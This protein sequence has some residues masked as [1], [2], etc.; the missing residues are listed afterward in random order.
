MQKT[1]LWNLYA[2]C[3]T[4]LLGC[5]FKKT[6]NPKLIQLNVNFDQENAPSGAISL[7]KMGEKQHSRLMKKFNQCWTTI[8]WIDLA[9][10][11]FSLSCSDLFS[12]CK[13]KK[14]NNRLDQWPSGYFWKPDKWY[15]N[16]ILSSH[17]DFLELF[18][19]G[20]LAKNSL[21]FHNLFNFLLQVKDLQI[22]LSALNNKWGDAA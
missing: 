12:S 20:L 22:A 5:S 14:N 1:V 11:Y 9:C 21:I 8:Y 18:L 4:Q 3:L 16:T 10:V 15:L 17:L 13:F 2:S 7:R 6:C 19:W